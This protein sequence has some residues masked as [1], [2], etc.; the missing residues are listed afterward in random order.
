MRR[1]V[2]ISR[3]LPSNPKEGSSHTCHAFDPLY[4]PRDDAREMRE[5]GDEAF[6]DRP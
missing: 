2:H 6:Q 5:I 1:M 4:R 3:K